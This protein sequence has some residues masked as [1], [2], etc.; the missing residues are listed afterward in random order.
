MTSAMLDCT[1]QSFTLGTASAA[2]LSLVFVNSVNNKSPSHKFKQ[3]LMA[4]IVFISARYKYVGV[5]FWSICKNLITFTRTEKL[6]EENANILVFFTS[7]SYRVDEAS[8]WRGFS[9]K[10]VVSVE[11]KGLERNNNQIKAENLLD[12]ST[13]G[14]QWGL[15]THHH[16]TVCTTILCWI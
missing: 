4:L 13:V 16:T 6:F 7:M 10:E 9:I 2:L 11:A 8:Q 14:T 5:N 1:H 12:S 3:T 15:L